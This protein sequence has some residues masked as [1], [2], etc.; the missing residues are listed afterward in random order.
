MSVSAR[1]LSYSFLFLSCLLYTCNDRERGF[2]TNIVSTAHAPE[3]APERTLPRAL[4]IMG[5]NRISR[6]YLS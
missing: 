1:V 2:C 6:R 4:G 3:Q 5:F